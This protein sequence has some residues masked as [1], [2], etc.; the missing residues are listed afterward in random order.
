MFLKN[1]KTKYVN[2]FG[3][4][5]HVFDINRTNDSINIV[6]QKNKPKYHEFRLLFLLNQLKLNYNAL[7]TI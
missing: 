4:G 6:R 5:K 7:R 3:Y 1:V 2:L